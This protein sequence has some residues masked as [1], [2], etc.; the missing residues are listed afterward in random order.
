MDTWNGRTVAAWLIDVIGICAIWMLAHFVFGG[1]DLARSAL[2]GVLIGV[3]LATTA[4]KRKR[5]SVGRRLGAKT[6]GLSCAEDLETL[7]G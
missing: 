2:V 5:R 3:G 6:C 7:D 4:A 1:D